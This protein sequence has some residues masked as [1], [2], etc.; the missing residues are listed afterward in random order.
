MTGTLTIS[1]RRALGS[2][3][4]Q[5][6]IEERHTDA[7]TITE[8]PVERGAPISDHAYRRPAEVVVQCGWSNSSRAAGGNGDYVREVYKALLALQESREPFDV[9]TGKR[10]YRNM[11]IASLAVTTDQ[12][13]EATLMVVATLREVIRVQTRVVAVPGAEVQANPKAT[14]ATHFTGVA[15]L[16]PA[17]LSPPATGG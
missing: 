1:P 9:S 3:S 15:Q 10:L 13:S 17:T 4:I 11:L 2:I 5:C 14:A 12:K 7:L 8:H 16:R 6:V